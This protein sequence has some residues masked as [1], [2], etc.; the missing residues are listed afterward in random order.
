M[1]TLIENG[2]V[3][4]WVDNRHKIFEPGVVVFAGNEIEFV[5]GRYDGDVDTRIDATSRIVMPGLINSHLHVT[6]TL[7]TKGYLE[8][9]GASQ[10]GAAQNF[11]ALYKVLPS[12]R[13]ATDPAAQGAAAHY[14]FA[15]LA[16]TGSTTV[17]EL[18]Y[19][20]DIGGKGCGFQ[21]RRSHHFIKEYSRG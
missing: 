15:E 11:A 13:N 7:Y 14:V 6:D 2:T 19:G 17:V 8:E 1:R 9:A 10:P 21:S 18:G 12:I 3:I 20:F 5:G 16:R 4:A